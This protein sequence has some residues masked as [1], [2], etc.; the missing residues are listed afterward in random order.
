MVIHLNGT[1]FVVAVDSLSCLGPYGSAIVA[2]SSAARVRV[3]D[4][5]KE[6]F[7]AGIP[8]H[9]P[10]ERACRLWEG[11]GVKG[12]RFLNSNYSKVRIIIKLFNY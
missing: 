7:Q 10:L 3:Y 8:K 4:I 12:I 9:M 11:Y 6:A 5:T 1:D 2:P